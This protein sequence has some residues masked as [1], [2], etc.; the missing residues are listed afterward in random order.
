MGNYMYVFIKCPPVLYS[1]TP[2]KISFEK[3]NSVR[4]NKFENQRCRNIF[5]WLCN[6][7]MRCPLLGS[8]VST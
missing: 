1:K 7:E 4:H 6:L 3:K 8:L 2:S 5:N